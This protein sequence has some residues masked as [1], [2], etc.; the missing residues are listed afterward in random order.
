[1][2]KVFH[3]PLDMM[4]ELDINVC[5]DPISLNVHVACAFHRYHCVAEV[6]TNDTD[7]AYYLTNTVDKNWINN[8]S[9]KFLGS[10]EYGLR[11]CRST[12]EGDVMITYDEAGKV[13]HKSIVASR[14]FVEFR[15]LPS[16]K[17]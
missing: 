14:G 4:R 1:M 13:T 10:P 6:L 16:T 11:C 8:R 5:R 2:I 9:V 7:T 17:L 15:P 12:S 3:A